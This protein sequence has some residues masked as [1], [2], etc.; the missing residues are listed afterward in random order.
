MLRILRTILVVLFI[1][2]TRDGHSY[3]SGMQRQAK[4]CKETYWTTG[5][6]RFSLLY[7]SLSS[8]LAPLLMLVAGPFLSSPFLS[9]PS[10]VCYTRASRGYTCSSCSAGITSEFSI[11]YLLT[12]AQRVRGGEKE[13][14]KRE[15]KRTKRKKRKIEVRT[16]N[17]N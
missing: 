9:F 11:F 7:F 14:E 1:C 5:A 17:V 16:S 6:W 8:L 3:A 12:L 10:L 2:G 13:G 4:D 15:E